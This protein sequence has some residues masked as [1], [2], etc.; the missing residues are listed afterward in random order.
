MD[1]LPS[2]SFMDPRLISLHFNKSLNCDIFWT[3]WLTS[4]L[5]QSLQG[6][7]CKV[8]D[9]FHCVLPL[10]PLTHLDDLDLYVILTYLI[11]GQGRNV[12]KNIWITK[13]AICNLF[14]AMLS[15]LH[16][17]KIFRWLEGNNSGI[18]RAIKQIFGI[19]WGK[20]SVS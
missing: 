18:A 19:T 9:L 13:H 2:N 5:F 4:R 16:C 10:I 20:K 15:V 12:Q 14:N 1:K 8:V 3:G 7:C 17:S 11:S 6:N